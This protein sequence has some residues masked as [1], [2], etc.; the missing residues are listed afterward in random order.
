MKRNKARAAKK[1]LKAKEDWDRELR[2][3]TEEIRSA[4]ER[5]SKS[6]LRRWKACS[7]VFNAEIGPGTSKRELLS[8]MMFE[9]VSLGGESSDAIFIYEKMW[10]ELVEEAMSEAKE[11]KQEEQRSRKKQSSMDSF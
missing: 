6:R 8:Q 4:E 9:V 7:E 10:H 11:A 5:R 3:R 1:E 2:A